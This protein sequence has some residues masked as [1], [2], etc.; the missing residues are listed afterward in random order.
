MW[1]VNDT[2]AY[3]IV[4]D[5]AKFVVSPEGTFNTVTAAVSSAGHTEDEVSDFAD[6]GADVDLEWHAHAFDIG[7]SG[8][9]RV[10]SVTVVLKQ[11]NDPLGEVWAEIWTDSGS[12]PGVIV[13]NPSQMVTIADIDTSDDDI[14]FN[15]VN[16]PLLA[17]STTYWVVLKTAGYAYTNGDTE[18]MWSV[19][20]DPASASDYF[21]K[22]DPDATPVFTV[23][24]EDH[25]ANI[26]VTMIGSQ[27]IKRIQ[28]MDLSVT[29]SRSTRTEMGTEDVLER[30]TDETD[31]RITVPMLSS[32]VTTW[33]RALGYNPTVVKTTRPEQDPEV[34]VRTEFYSNDQR[35]EDDFLLAY[36]FPQVQRSGGEKGI[37]AN[38]RGTKR[39]T[40]SGDEF[41]ITTTY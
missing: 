29:F 30:T 36:E 1:T 2:A 33:A 39:V 25:V 18:L 21:V 28:G 32:D 38:D 12:L 31:S 3:G 22:G 7:A 9:G 6:S 24:D 26:V 13:D 11:L 37:A 19:F 34:Y 35:L 16:G 14:T 10:A 15:F 8:A 17:A 20:H 41:S 27:E 23:V 40:M 4:H 5:E